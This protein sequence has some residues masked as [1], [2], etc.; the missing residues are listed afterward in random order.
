MVVFTVCHLHDL[1]LSDP[2]HLTSIQYIF[3]TLFLNK[4]SFKDLGFRLESMVLEDTIQSLTTFL[5]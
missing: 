5:S 3:R 2:N 4:T 1:D